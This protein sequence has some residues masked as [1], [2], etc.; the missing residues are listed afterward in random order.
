[1]GYLLIIGWG[2]ESARGAGKFSGG[3]NAN[4]GQ[5]KIGSQVSRKA[6]IPFSQQED[7]GPDEAEANCKDVQAQYAILKHRYQE[8]TPDGCVIFMWQALVLWT[9]VIS[10]LVPCIMWLNKKTN[11]KGK[12]VLITGGSKGIGLSLA[13]EALAR[14][15]NVSIIA[16]NTAD[17]QAAQTKLQ[18]LGPGK[19]ISA[20]ADTASAEQVRCTA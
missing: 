16:R 18:D 17:L 15:A 10:V 7:R 19:V 4:V 1:M 14:G 2:S 5:S 3:R 9:G 8:L 13:E 12:H 20:S 6:E 11:F